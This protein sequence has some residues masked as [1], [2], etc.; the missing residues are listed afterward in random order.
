MVVA[1][2][3]RKKEQKP[4]FILPMQFVSARVYRNK[5]Y[6]SSGCRVDFCVTTLNGPKPEIFGSKVFTNQACTGW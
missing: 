5:A 4:T 6:F 1:R 3:L 2:R